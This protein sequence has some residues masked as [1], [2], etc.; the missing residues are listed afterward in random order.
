M[1]RLTAEQVWARL[2][3]EQKDFFHEINKVKELAQA[4][5][6]PAKKEYLEAMAGAMATSMA[7]ELGYQFPD[8][9]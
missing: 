7:K 6:D 9:W 8:R 2:T 3:Q 1:M 4:E 5:T